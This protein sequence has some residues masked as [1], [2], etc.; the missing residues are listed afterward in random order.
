MPP[1]SSGNFNYPSL[2]T[3]NPSFTIPSTAAAAANPAPTI[4]TISTDNTY[5]NEVT[6]KLPVQDESKIHFNDLSSQQ[7]SFLS[8]P[9]N[10][11]LTQSTQLPSF[12][13][14][15]SG[16][17]NIFQ[18]QLPS[19]YDQ[20]PVQVQAFA[21][22]QQQSGDN[23]KYTGGFGGAPGILGQQKPGVLLPGHSKPV[24]LQTQQ[25]ALTGKKIFNF[26]MKGI[27]Y[28]NILYTL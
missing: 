4:S 2:G 9:K 22:T 17:T 25:P 18:S 12:T 13:P 20:I 15:N 8:S 7:G 1:L 11:S 21:V 26:L 5:Q 10:P 24:T 3:S 14:Q 23:G 28:S 19:K 6:G 16:F 27:V